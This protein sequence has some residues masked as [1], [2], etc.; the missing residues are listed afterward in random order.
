M[1]E[2]KGA[3]SLTWRVDSLAVTA[4][5]PFP[6]RVLETSKSLTQESDSVEEAPLGGEETPAGSYFYPEGDFVDDSDW[7]FALEGD[8]DSRR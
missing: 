8:E 7:L 6:T 2:R 4:S 5:D 3:E 1:E